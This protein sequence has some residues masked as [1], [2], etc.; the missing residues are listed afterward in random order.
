MEG[1][2]ATIQGGQLAAEA[3]IRKGI[4]YVF[5]LSGGHITPIYQYLEDSP[6]T[7]VDTRH[8]QSA[9]FMAEVFGR[10]TRRPGIAMVTAGPG[11]TNSLSAI[12]NAHFSNA[13]IV[14]ISPSS[15]PW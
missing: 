14:L 4:E 13:P 1:S 8:E 10:M 6:V 2:V 9:V 5:T 15:N 3:L 11:F 7:L 12:A